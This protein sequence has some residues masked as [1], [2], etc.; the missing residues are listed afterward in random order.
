MGDEDDTIVEAK[1]CDFGS[2][3]IGDDPKSC[4]DD[5]RRFGVTLFS[6]ATGAGWTQNRLIH[7]THEN[8]V[9]QLADAVKDSDDPTLQRLPDVL[10]QILSGSMQMKEVAALMEEF[11]DNYED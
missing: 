3:Q 8:L 6:V 7:E 10:D 5:I 1:L 9:S 4:A 2:A 11:A